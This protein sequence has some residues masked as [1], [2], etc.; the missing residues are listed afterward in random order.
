MEKLFE[1]TNFWLIWLGC[2]GS[3]EGTSLFKIQSDWKIKTNY[4]YHKETGLGKPLFKDML[5]QG[6]LDNGKSGLVAKLDW[7]PSYVL[8]NHKL[9]SEANGGWTLNTFIIEKMPD[10]Q[11][12]IESNKA[13]LFDSILVSSLYRGNLDTIKREGRTIFDDIGLF[14]FVSNLIP[15]CKRY[16]ADIVVRMIFTMISFQSEKDLLGYFNALRQKIPEDKIPKIIDNEGD[17][18]RILYPLE[19]QSGQSGK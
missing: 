4:L 5:E 11:K 3:A 17:L 9:P 10:I 15:F 13:I 8:E 18:V 19:Q 16:G 2:A 7:I 14:V 6:Y 12:F 1:Y